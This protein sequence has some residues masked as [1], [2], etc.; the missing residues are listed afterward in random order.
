MVHLRGE[1]T[2]GN[3]FLSQHKHAYDHAF[4]A[5][6]C[7]AAGSPLLFISDNDEQIYLVLSPKNAV[8]IPAELLNSVGIPGTH[9]IGELMATPN[10]K[11]LAIEGFDRSS[12]ASNKH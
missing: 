2:D 11:A 12:S 7:V 3:C 8:S 4:C 5:K 10:V 1:L 6:L 9:V